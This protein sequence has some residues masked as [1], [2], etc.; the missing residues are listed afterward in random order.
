[1]AP[2][3]L[4]SASL[5]SPTVASLPC[6]PEPSSARSPLPGAPPSPALLAG[7][8]IALPGLRGEGMSLRVAGT[9]ACPENPRLGQQAEL[10]RLPGHLS[11]KQQVMACTSH[12]SSGTWL[13]L[14][15]LQRKSASWDTALLPSTELTTSQ[16]GPLP[17]PGGP[18]QQGARRA[19]EPPLCTEH[20]AASATSYPP[21]LFQGSFLSPHQ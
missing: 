5:S 20:P 8:L 21:H 14:W 6:I 3:D 11:P 4:S 16:Q 10:S 18:A 9:L 7:A 2:R 15:P 17:S 19:R 12:Y 13:L 1:M